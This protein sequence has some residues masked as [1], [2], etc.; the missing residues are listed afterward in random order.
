MVVN[1]FL[2]IVDEITDSSKID[3]VCNEVSNLMMFAIN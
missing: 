3:D 2:E 1:F